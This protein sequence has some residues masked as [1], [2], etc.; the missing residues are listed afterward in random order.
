MIRLTSKWKLKKGL[1]PELLRNL[2]STA[3]RFQ[4]S[5]KGS[6][7]Y[8]VHLEEPNSAETPSSFSNLNL[9][10]TQGAITFIETYNDIGDN[11]RKLKGE[12]FNNFLEE[13][14]QYFE[15]DPEKP[16]W[17]VIDA[18]MLKLDSGQIYHGPS[19]I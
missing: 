13:N 1:S 10:R 18:H 3:E 5:K 7:T 9:N 17:P 19:Y 4:S 14:L 2:E 11:Y 15:E 6:L 12:I 16:G 8:L